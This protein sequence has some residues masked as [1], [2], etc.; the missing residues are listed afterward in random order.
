MQLP[1]WMSDLFMCVGCVYVCACVACAEELSLAQGNIAK[2]FNLLAVLIIFSISLFPP[3]S[4]R[5]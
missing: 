1:V 2:L 4:N 5:T 3:P